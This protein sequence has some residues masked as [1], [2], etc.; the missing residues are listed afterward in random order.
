LITAG[1]LAARGNEK[2]DL[3][4]SAK[5]GLEFATT[6]AVLARDV[7]VAITGNRTRSKTSRNFIVRK[8][9]KVMFER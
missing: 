9:R 8:A 1:W 3:R 2:A 4:E 6:V 5:W 7:I